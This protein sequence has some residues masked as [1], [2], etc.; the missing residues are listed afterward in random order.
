MKKESF[1]KL[2]VYQNG[3]IEKIDNENV[4]QKVQLEE[5]FHSIYAVFFVGDVSFPEDKVTSLKN[6]K[7]VG[8][9]LQKG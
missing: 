2:R 1:M 4:V 3:L 6:N 8:M 9:D 5:K 7:K